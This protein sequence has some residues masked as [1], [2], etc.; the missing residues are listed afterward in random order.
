L[1]H[2]GAPAGGFRVLFQGQ[3]VN[4]KGLRHLVRAFRELAPSLQLFLLGG[5][6]LQTPLQKLCQRLR[7]GN[8]F[9][10]A[11][12]PQ[13]DLLRYVAHANLGIIPYSGRT[14]LNNRYCTPNKLFEFIEAEIPICANDLPELRRIVTGNGIGA[15]SPM[16]DAAAMARAVEACR[17]QCVQGSFTPAALRQARHKFAWEKQAKTLLQ[18]Y[19]QLG[20]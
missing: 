7:I 17:Q 4:D 10:G 9:F 15:V 19:E 13:A 2:F 8:V 6:P 18:L 11:W 1:Q 12:V 3:L 20:V 16:E 14:L 5:G